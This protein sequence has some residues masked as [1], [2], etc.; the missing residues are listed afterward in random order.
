MMNWLPMF[1]LGTAS[2]DIV[3]LD[4]REGQVCLDRRTSVIVVN[5]PPARPDGTIRVE[6]LVHECF[7]QLKPGGLLYLRLDNWFWS[8]SITSRLSCVLLKLMGRHSPPMADTLVSSYSTV[9][10]MLRKS[11]FDRIR[12]F[13]LLPYGDAPTHMIPLDRRNVVEFFLIN[14]PWSRSAGDWTKKALF[15]AAARLGLL[16]LFVPSYCVVAEKVAL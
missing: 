14:V 11:G 7:E 15:R 9:E 6:P 12:C 4:V 10:R 1:S 16:K 5:R 13:A 2:D 8:S 3:V